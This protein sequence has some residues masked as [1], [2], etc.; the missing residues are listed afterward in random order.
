MIDFAAE[1][2]IVDTSPQ[3]SEGWHAAR[4]G[5]CTGSNTSAMRARSD[6]LANKQQRAFV[7]A[8]RAGQDEATA[9]A[10]AGYKAKP[11]ID[12][13]DAH[14]KG[15]APKEWTDTAKT[16]AMDVA[17]EME[18]GELPAFFE[19]GAARMG[20]EQEPHGATAYEAKTG[21]ELET[22]GFVCTGDRRFGCSIDRMVVGVRAA[23]EIKTMV[24]SATLFKAVVGGDIS[25]Y[26]DQ[27]LFAMWLLTLEWIDLCLWC[28]D[29]NYL[30]VVRIERN[31]ELLQALQDDVVAFGKL[32]DQHAAKLRAVMSG[33]P[34]PVADLPMVE[35]VTPTAAPAPAPNK[36]AAKAK[37]LA[38]ATTTAAPVAIAVPSF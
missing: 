21:R 17:R 19:G 14:V 28:P 36:K 5:V 8:L 25:E 31:E 9:L 34:L 26:L 11:K 23:V 29:L 30:H 10:A 20:H 37:T 38:P 3:N 18:G 2:F 6:G 15:T 33:E 1:G 32:V 12:D 13:L 16:Y 35:E 4:R 24:S 7:A 27:C 22:I